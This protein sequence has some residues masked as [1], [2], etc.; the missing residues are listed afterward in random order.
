[1][2]VLCCHIKNLCKKSSCV[3]L[4][5]FANMIRG[6]RRSLK[7]PSVKTQDS[8]KR[9]TSEMIWIFDKACD[10]NNSSIL[11]KKIKTIFF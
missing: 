3:I 1:M 4:F 6:A 11:F 10:N 2:A 8:L 9:P 5:V 7:D